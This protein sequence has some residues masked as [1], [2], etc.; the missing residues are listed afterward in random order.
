MESKRV[1]NTA[2]L[3]LLVWSLES[4]ESVNTDWLLAALFTDIL[5][6]PPENGVLEYC[7]YFGLVTNF[8]GGYVSFSKG[9]FFLPPDMK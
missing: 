8:R 7:F 2:L 9:T 5:T 4:I 6:C 3:T 1:L